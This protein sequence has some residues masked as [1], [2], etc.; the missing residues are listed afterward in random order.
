LSP[1]GRYRA[2]KSIELALIC[3]PQLLRLGLERVLRA[4][5]GLSV[6][7]R[8]G[9]ADITGPVDVAVIC[10]RDLENT[11]LVCERA[12]SAGARAVVVVLR[13]PQPEPMLACLAAGAD[14]FVAENDDPSELARAIRAAARGEYHVAHGPL[15]VLLDWHRAQRRSRSERSRQRDRDLLALL[16]SGR[17]TEEIAQRLGIAPKTVRNRTSLLYRRLGVR[18]RAQAASA[19]EELGVL[20]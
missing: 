3:R 20:D 11:H 19:A 6:S 8:A 5:P 13:R 7:S 9:P 14:G 4:D 18:S 1:H 10:E 17:S 15:T 2:K 16:A 12:R